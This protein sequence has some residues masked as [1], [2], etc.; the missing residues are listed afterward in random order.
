MILA[1]CFP[2]TCVVL[3][4]RLSRCMDTCVLMRCSYTVVLRGLI[5]DFCFTLY[6]KEPEPSV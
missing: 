6:D 1:Y 3:L 4:F 2:S 5:A